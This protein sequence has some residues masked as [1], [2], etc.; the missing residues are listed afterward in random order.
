[1]NTQLNSID[2][3]EDE[4]AYHETMARYVDP[5]TNPTLMEETNTQLRFAK[6]Q[7]RVFIYKA[8]QSVS[9]NGRSIRR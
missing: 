7:R 3:I 4:I 9:K 5:D 6:E 1:M 8:H 2:A